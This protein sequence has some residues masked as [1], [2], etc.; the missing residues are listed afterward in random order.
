ML[1]LICSPWWSFLWALLLHINAIYEFLFVNNLLSLFWFVQGYWGTFDSAQGWY[2]SCPQVK[3]GGISQA[4]WTGIL[5][6]CPSYSSLNLI[7]SVQLNGNFFFFFCVNFQWSA[8]FLKLIIW[9]YSQ[10]KFDLIFLIVYNIMVK[11]LVAWFAC[12]TMFLLFFSLRL[13][14]GV[15][16][17]LMK[18]LLQRVGAYDIPSGD[19]GV[20][21]YRG[22]VGGLNRDFWAR[23]D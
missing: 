6:I 1:I 14:R 13:G 20:C 10:L 2:C 17:A 5:S 11:I 23:L 7:A 21:C 19:G 4:N 18:F 9:Q 8:V 3:A 22:R 12:A 16:W 15:G